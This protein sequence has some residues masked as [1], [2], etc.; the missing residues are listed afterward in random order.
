MTVAQHASH[1]SKR[2]I[3]NLLVEWGIRRCRPG[4]VAGLN[5]ACDHR[6]ALIVMTT[7]GG[8]S[9]CYQAPAVCERGMT[10]VISPL[11]SLM[12]DQVAALIARGVPAAAVNSTMHHRQVEEVYRHAAGG[13]HKLLYVAP[14]RLD[15]T[16]FLTM[17]TRADVR[18]I[19]VDE[20][21][22]VSAWGHDFRPAYSQIARL[23][24]LL[25]DARMSAFTATAGSQV[26]TEICESLGLRDPVVYVGDFDRPNLNLRVV[27]RDHGL[28]R[29]GSYADRRID[30]AALRA[31]TGNGE[32]GII[33]VITRVQADRLS[34]D[35]HDAGIHAL[36]YHAGLSADTRTQ[37]QCMFMDNDVPVIVATIAFGMGIDKPDVRFVFHASLPSSLEVYHQEIGRAGRD[38]DPADCVLYWHEDDVATWEH[39]LDIQPEDI[40]SAVDGI[41]A[42]PGAGRWLAL[43]NMHSFCEQGDACRHA[44]L[45]AHFGAPHPAAN[46]GA[47]DVCNQY[48]DREGPP[49]PDPSRERKRPDS[50]P[51]SHED[52]K[53]ECRGSDGE[54]S[55]PQS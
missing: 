35:L 6:D 12:L 43:C 2:Y 30:L 24:K 25:P 10:L 19:V 42:T 11:I 32:S 21:H 4:Q 28:K 27:H 39:V 5:A 18:A 8:K 55:V 14:E 50:S 38:G 44:S 7:G 41:A 3:M 37:T 46:C 13:G 45:V 48:R 33:Y 15:N 49:R 52:T 23:R 9:L 47:C 26:R 16:E 22:C 51:R 36:P 29:S 31:H 54:Y 17:L 1:G 40:E 53:A 34:E 20:A